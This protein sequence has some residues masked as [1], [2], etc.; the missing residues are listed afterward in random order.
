MQHAL[1]HALV[2][3]RN[4]DAEL[5]VC[6]LLVALGERFAEVAKA[7]AHSAAAG[8]VLGGADLGLT[9][10]LERRNVIGHAFEVSLILIEMMR[11]RMQRS[12]HLS[13]YLSLWESGKR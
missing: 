11:W 12:P 7:G 5:L 2:Q 9:G 13:Q 3:G 6:R 10:A 8:A 1:L 4:R